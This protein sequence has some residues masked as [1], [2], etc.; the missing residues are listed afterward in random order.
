[1]ALPLEKPIICPIIVGRR[2]EIDS[3]QRALEQVRGGRGETLV[4]AGEAGIGKSRLI[5]EA[6]ERAAGLGFLCLQGHCFE[7]DVALPYAPLVDLLQTRMT[8]MSTEELAD[9]FASAP[10]LCTLLPDLAIGVPGVVPPAPLEPEQEKRRLFH[11]LARLIVAQTSAQPVL[12]V[13]EDLHWSDATSLEFLRYLA[14]RTAVHPLLL[15]LSYR[16]DEVGPGL[17]HFLAELDR[18]RLG[19]ELVLAP[20]TRASVEAMLRAIFD[21]KRPVRGEFVDAL[22][23]LTEGNPFFVEEALKAL[24]I[25]DNLAGAKGPWNS[26]RLDDVRI[27]RSVQ[28]AVLRRLVHVSARAQQALTVAAVAGRRFDFSLLRELTGQD[29]SELLRD[30]KELVAAQLVVEQS[31]ERFAF[32]HT[33]TRQAIY[34]Q[35]LAR[36]RQELH[37]AIVETIERLHNDSLE[38]H[39]PDVAYHAY[40]AERWEKALPYARRMGEQAQA[41]GAPRAAIEHFTHALEAASQLGQPPSRELYR[42]RGQMYETQGEFE[43]AQDDYL[44]ALAAARGVGDSGAEWQAL[45]DLGFLWLARD[46]DRAGGYFHQARDLASR[47][48]DPK[49]LAHSLNRLGNWYANL[50]RPHEGQDLHR[51]ALAIFGDLGDQ[52]G[53]AE[54]LDLLAVATH[55]GGDRRGA[56]TH[57]EEAAALFRELGDRQALASVLA[58]LGHVRCA[59]LVYVTL[60]GA[61]PSSGQALRECEEALTITRTIGWRSGEAY[62][63]SE[64]AA[65][66]SAEGEYGRA[67]AAAQES[68]AIAEEIEHREWLAIAH[69]TLGMMYLDL[70]DAH[71]ARW[72]CERA[73]AQARETGAHHLIGLAAAF[74]AWARLLGEEQERAKAVLHDLAPLEA[75]VETLTQSVLLAAYGELSLA[76]GDPALAL[77]VADQLIAWAEQSHGAGVIPR[78]WKLRGEALAALGRTAEAEAV[79][80]AARDAAHAQG[81]RPLLWRL[82][83][84]LGALF[85]AQGRRKDAEQAYTAAR[86]LIEELAATIPEDALRAAFR[87]RALASVPAPR[88][89]SSRRIAKDRYGGL[90]ARE[91]EVVAHI[92]RGL[93]NRDIAAA[94][95]ISERTVEA[96]SGHIRDKLGCA[97]RA[98]VAAWAV[99]QGLLPDAT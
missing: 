39:L 57:Y 75:P 78:L 7:P 83:V 11:S 73:Y 3:L 72:H 67:L 32:R 21:Q 82:H 96:H 10:E 87:S 22:Y 97:S 58:T 33:L 24:A 29:E 92:A 88:P 68:L 27:P 59:S 80:E 69:S 49:R 35:L 14:R 94:L 36:E 55:V 74:L 85:Q 9:V 43:Q 18:E 93:S 28:D 30:M 17:R 71:T 52:P 63:L 70:L 84:A 65:C 54:T 16:S 86:S 56:I 81:S 23:T 37:W 61:A 79:L 26:E 89:S 42:A 34:A 53:I 95:V 41:M 38:A 45:L 19:Q 12:M 50:D 25:G 1:M 15:I 5:T 51:Q 64:L 60:P 31:A 40:A 77:G 76:C 8:D 13:V 98:Q 44:R 62:A 20:L 2:G 48:D 4:L 6:R 99:A 47:M 90:T 91:R 66:L 46:Y